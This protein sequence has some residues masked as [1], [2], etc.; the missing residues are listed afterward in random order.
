MRVKIGKGKACGTVQAPPSKSMAHR[1]LICA[2]LAEGKSVIHGIAPSEDVLA[3]IDCLHA[4]GIRCELERDTAVVYG[5]RLRELYRDTAAEEKIEEPQG[6]ENPERTLICRESGSTL[7]FFI[8]ICLTVGGKTA[9]YGSG[10]LMERP[11]SV[12]RKICEEQ[13]ISFCQ[14]EKGI[15]TEGRLQA[16][17]FSLAG[18]IS[19]QFISG[20]L[21]ALPQLEADSTIRIQPP[22]E[23]RSYIEMTLSALASFGIRA[24]WKD[25]NTLY[26]K[27]RQKFMPQEITVEGDY[28]NAAFF[29][30]LNVIGGQVSIGNLNENS[31]QGDR[32][33]KRLFE[34]L[35][36]RNKTEINI[37]DCPDLGPILFT[38]AAAAGGGTFSGCRRLKIKESNR[39]EVMASELK[40]FGV[41][42]HVGEDEVVVEN[43]GIYPPETMLD[44]HNDHRIVMSCAVLLTL[45]GGEIQGAEAVTKSFPDF[46]EKLA[47]LGIEVTKI[48][49]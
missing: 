43:T 44:G 39:G 24:G 13:Q 32:V 6:A 37:S 30:A 12:Y 17:D 42:V 14:N 31:L 18:N 46:F 48:E 11:Q 35:K 33:Y 9:F 25:K 8:P 28:S 36:Q 4:L 38:V 26:V 34:E 21:F 7:R 22:V 47:S 20:L 40:K 1:L 23:S 10:R 3:T 2:G 27:G 49:N 29:E 41:Q 5:R 19:S 16:G 15:L 45:T